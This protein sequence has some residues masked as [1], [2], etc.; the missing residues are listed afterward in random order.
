MRRPPLISFPPDPQL[1]AAIQPCLDH[2]GVG[3]PE[4]DWPNNI[5]STKSVIYG[6]GRIARAGEPIVHQVD[7]DELDLIRRLAHDV[8]KVMLN[9]SVGM[10][11]SASDPFREYY[12][13]ANLDE[14]PPVKIDESLIRSRFAGTIFPLATITVEPLAESG[15]W[16]SEVVADGEGD[17]RY[18]YPWRNMIQWFR[19][20]PEFIDRAFTRI[21]D[22]DALA[23][24]DSADLPAGTELPGGVLPRLALGLTKQGSL[25][26]LFG[27]SV[28][29]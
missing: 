16:W 8:A 17:G 28:Q 23:Q 27:C 24:L 6:S 19:T 2:Y 5:L 25:A 1:Q 22:S 4:A 20:Q 3:D 10:G 14:K 12:C 18:L 21:G 13:A 11:S 29:A 9:V 26:G 15:T 7:P